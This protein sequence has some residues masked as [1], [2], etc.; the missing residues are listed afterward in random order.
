VAL[1][2]SNGCDDSVGHAVSAKA[3]KSQ[4][5]DES[6]L[7]GISREFGES[8][9]IVSDVFVG[10]VPR[11][12]SQESGQTVQ[13][14]VSGQNGRSRGLWESDLL[15]GSFETISRGLNPSVDFVGSRAF[16]ASVFWVLDGDGAGAGAEGAAAKGLGASSVSA[17]SGGLIAVIAVAVVVIFVLKH[18]KRSQETEKC[19]DYEADGQA[20]DVAESES[21]EEDVE[22]DWDVDSFD[23]VIEDAFEGPM[24]MGVLSDSRFEIESDE[25]F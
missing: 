7:F 23:R 1:L 24:E 17:I 5:L 21:E 10:S 25:L 20:T 4:I 8:G 9:A 18:L 19:S 15:N 22:D 16:S 2:T 12:R 3:G 6:G 13:F 14:P 11:I